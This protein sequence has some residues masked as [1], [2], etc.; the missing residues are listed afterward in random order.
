VGTFTSKEIVDLI[1]RRNGEHYPEEGSAYD[2][3]RI[4]QY[5]TPEGDPNNWGAVFR[6]EVS[7]GMLDRY[8]HASH[9]INPK[10]VFTRKEPE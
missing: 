2:I 7:M 9:C 6:C 4:T 5:T 1:I 10:I 3:V 8:Q